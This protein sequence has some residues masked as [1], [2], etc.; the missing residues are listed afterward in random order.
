MA[1]Y[2]VLRMANTVYLSTGGRPVHGFEVIV[3][4]PE[5]DEEYTANIPSSSPK[6]IDDVIRAYLVNR[7]AIAK[8]G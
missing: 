2:S 4:L 5:F 7:R 6:D 3:Y 1:D 8:L